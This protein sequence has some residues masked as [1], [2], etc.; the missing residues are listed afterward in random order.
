[1]RKALVTGGAGFIGSHLVEKLL[2]ENWEVTVVDNFDPFYDPSVKIRNVA[3]C[4][5][6]AAFQFL[7]ADIRDADLSRRLG[8]GRFDAVV[9]LAGKAGVR[10]SIEDPLSYQDVNVRG[11]QQ[12]LELCRTLEIPRCIFA[13][14]SSVYGVNPDV[15]WHEETA[16]LQPIS[17]YAS[18]KISGEL[19][20]HVYSHLY[21][22]RFIALRFFTVYGPRQRPDLAIHKF[23][24]RITQGLPL[25]LFGDGKS[26]RDYTYIDDIVA[27]IRAAM[28][29]SASPYEIFNLG[30]GEPI[31]LIDMVRT[32]SEVSTIPVRIESLPEQAG[33]VPQTYASIDKASRMLGYKPRVTFRE[34]IQRFMEWY[35]GQEIAH[36]RG[37]TGIAPPPSA[38]GDTSLPATKYR[39]SL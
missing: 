13:S 28:E 9:H 2:G 18:T 35:N 31:R 6:H 32:I 19:M 24:H 12:I 27:G 23:I 8:S 22:I 37:I 34:G 17:P 7:N 5:K 4:R 26:M 38:V 11:T 30:C 10:P 3:A 1:M 33:D 16:V 21:G 25:P 29:Y 39:A 14:S 20:G 36:V 15:P